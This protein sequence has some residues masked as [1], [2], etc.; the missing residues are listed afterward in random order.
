MAIKKE[1]KLFFIILLILASVP[2][3][4]SYIDSVSSTI[5]IIYPENNTVL[6]ANHTTI[7]TTINKNISSCILILDKP[8]WS[9]WTED[10]IFL[11]TTT[12]SDIFKKDGTLY[13]I[14]GDIRNGNLYGKNWTGTSWQTDDNIVRGVSRGQW[15]SDAKP[16]VFKMNKTWYLIA[17][18]F[19]SNY[20]GFNWNGTSWQEDISITVG[21]TGNDGQWER[22][23]VFEMDKVFYFFGSGGFRGFSTYAWNGTSWIF[24][25]TIKVGIPNYKYG[26]KPDIDTFKINDIWY[27]ITIARN[28][29]TK[30]Y[31]WTGTSWQENIDII[32]NLPVNTGPGSSAVWGHNTV[33]VFSEGNNMYALIAGSF[34]SSA[35]GIYNMNITNK[36]AS[37]NMTNI[38]EGEHTYHIICEDAQGREYESDT[39]KL[40]IDTSINLPP[41]WSNSEVNIFKLKKGERSI[42]FNITLTDDVGAGDYIFSFNDGSGWIN[43]SANS[44]TNN[45]QI[46]IVKTFLRKN[47]KG[48]KI[49]EGYLWFNDSR[50][51]IN[52][53]ESWKISINSK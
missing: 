44:W 41:I 30:G 34:R 33:N 17:G 12:Y 13:Q 16:T 42:H 10:K 18:G 47:I 9:N 45:T 11:T 32:K 38:K 19:N 50:G 3:V 15:D 36:T 46:E 53:T 49:V 22:S 29:P 35:S 4:L 43:D 20:K 52:I 21:L 8:R 14:Y 40:T 37:Y 2:L 48:K 7:N 25:P 27:A 28:L 39:N 23:H 51:N 24:N 6:K 31:H 1:T 26:N 5:N